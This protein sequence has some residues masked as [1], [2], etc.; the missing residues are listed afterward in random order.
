M[1]VTK[2]MRVAKKQSIQ[3]CSEIHTKKGPNTRKKNGYRYN[4]NFISK[5]YKNPNDTSTYQY[6]LASAKS[7]DLLL[8]ITKGK[9]FSNPVNNVGHNRY[10]TW[11]GNVMQVDYKKK[12][13]YKKFS[14]TS[15]KNNSNTLYLPIILDISISSN[16]VDHQNNIFY[17][18]CYF[19]TSSHIPPW[20][21]NV[22]TKTPIYKKRIIIIKARKPTH[23]EVWHIPKKF[24]LNIKSP[25]NNMILH[26]QIIVIVKYYNI[27]YNKIDNI[28]LY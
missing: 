4:K 15:V 11:G 28:L 9:R 26:A 7:Y 25:V 19:T 8:D 6:R 24:I 22:V 23:L 20:I 13:P 3:K 16:I 27:Y 21:Q 14:H 2:Q 5:R 10:K 17:S 18:P 12:I 1:A